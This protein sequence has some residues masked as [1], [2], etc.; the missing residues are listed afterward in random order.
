M[1]YIVEL[2]YIKGLRNKQSNKEKYHQMNSQFHIQ[3]ESES[4]KKI[5]ILI[6]KAA[7]KLPEN[8]SSNNPNEPAV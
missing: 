2:I 5:I 3:V 4:Q 1:T 8:V 7:L 6:N